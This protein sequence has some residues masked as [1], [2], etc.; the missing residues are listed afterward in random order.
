MVSAFVW[1]LPAAGQSKRFQWQGVRQP[2]CADSAY[3]VVWLP[4]T[5]LLVLASLMPHAGLWQLAVPFMHQLVCMA[6]FR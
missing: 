5:V 2:C 1:L 3:S 4:A 6:C